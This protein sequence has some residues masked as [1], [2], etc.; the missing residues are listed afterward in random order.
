MKSPRALLQIA[1]RDQLLLHISEHLSNASP[2]DT[3]DRIEQILG[4]TKEQ[5]ANHGKVYSPTTG[6]PVAREVV[7]GQWKINAR[8]RRW[9]ANTIP[10]RARG[11]QP[12]RWPRYLI[13]MLG[14]EYV[15]GTGEQP[16]FSTFDSKLSKFEAFTKPFLI[17]FKVRNHKNWVREYVE[18]RKKPNPYNSVK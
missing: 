1:D 18:E 12:V 2:D 9:V 6:K 14:K 11:G 8:Q 10:T 7:G 4:E 16:S 13:S 17:H 15:L 5:I 3:A